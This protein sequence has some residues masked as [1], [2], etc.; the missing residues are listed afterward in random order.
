MIFSQFR[1][2]AH[3][4]FEFGAFVTGHGC[5][6]VSG[7]VQVC[8]PLVVTFEFCLWRPLIPVGLVN[9]GNDPEHSGPQPGQK[10]HP[11][12]KVRDLNMHFCQPC[13]VIGA[14]C[15]W[16]RLY[17]AVYQ[18]SATLLLNQTFLCKFT[19]K[20]EKKA[21]GKLVQLT[22]VLCSNVQ[23]LHICGAASSASSFE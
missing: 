14:G 18:P 8:R 6:S 12:A 21:K 9:G 23:H 20:R 13:S 22:R 10:V 16:A 3:W 15:V 1:I 4:V 5:S 19:Q 17:G 7:W 2:F 11:L